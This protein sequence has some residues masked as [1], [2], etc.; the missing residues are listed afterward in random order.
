VAAFAGLSAVLLGLYYFPYAEGGL[1]KAWLDAYLRGYASS[2]GAVLGWLDPRV[3]VAGPTIV[4]RYSLRIVRTC[5][6]MD[7]TILLVAAMVSWPG[8]WRRRLVGAAAG[9]FALYVVNVARIC[10]LYYVGVYFPVAFEAAHL[11]V[12]PV[13]ILGVALALFYASVRREAW[14]APKGSPH[15]E[16]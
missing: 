3:H 2:A 15:A 13:I 9:A 8:A 4:G 10:S 7:A 6:A 16:L 14:T 11:E 5:D 12:W 1:A